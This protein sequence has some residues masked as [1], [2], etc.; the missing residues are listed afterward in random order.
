M[1]IYFTI[2][3]LIERKGLMLFSRSRY[4]LFKQDF[5]H[6]ERSNQGSEILTFWKTEG[7]Q[8][9]DIIWQCTKSQA[10]LVKRWLF[11]NYYITGFGFPSA[12]LMMVFFLYNSTVT[13]GDNG[14]ELFLLSFAS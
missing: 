6:I 10:M 3:F 7:F 9:H 4:A 12:P 11:H 13:K 5:W 2:V 1:C 8:D 14:R